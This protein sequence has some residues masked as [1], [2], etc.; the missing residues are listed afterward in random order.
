MVDG[1]PVDLQL[2]GQ[3]RLHVA[4]QQMVVAA[5]G[6]RLL[7]GIALSGGVAQRVRLAGTLWPDSSNGRAFAN[8]R[9]ALAR[10]P[11]RLRPEVVST[12]STVG[13]TE[14]WSVDVDEAARAARELRDRDDPAD[15][16][17]LLFAHDL[18]PDWSEDWLLV[19]R[20]RH[21]QLRLHALEDL[22]RIQLQAGDA[23]TAVDTALQAVSADELRESSQY[24][25]IEAHLA[26]GNRAAAL[27]QYGR[28]RRALC[29]ELGVEPSGATRELVRA[30]G[31]PPRR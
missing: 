23:L 10:L 13:F 30:A 12:S 31:I 14:A 5:T 24:L 11:T 6:Q 28:F 3:F 29:A 18:L 15:C 4:G 17:C 9:G 25:L 1:T 16:D 22:A 26:A 2:L 8:L 21:R 27:R 20:E 7:A 19:Q